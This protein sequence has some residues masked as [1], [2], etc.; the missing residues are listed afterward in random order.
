MAEAFISV[1]LEVIVNKLLS[2]GGAES[3]LKYVKGN[4]I[5]DKTIDDLKEN[6]K[7][8]HALLTDAQQ[9]RIESEE[10]KI[11][12]QELQDLAFDLEDILDELATDAQLQQLR[13]SF[14]EDSD[15]HHADYGS[16]ERERSTACLQSA[17]TMV[18]MSMIFI[19]D[20]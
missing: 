10:Y 9:R 17:N 6:L 1:L 2:S 18:R 20:F 12:V 4:K 11:W 5:D 14:D 13:Q 19:F 8:V 16:K 3:I 7:L 15:D